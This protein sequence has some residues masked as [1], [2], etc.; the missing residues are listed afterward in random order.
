[1]QG[2]LPSQDS[3]DSHDAC[4]RSAWHPSRLLLVEE[5]VLC[6]AIAAVGFVYLFTWLP[7]PSVPVAVARSME[8]LRNPFKAVPPE[9]PVAVVP[10]S[11]MMVA[12]IKRAQKLEERGR[13]D[14][15]TRAAWK[16]AG[17]ELLR[18]GWLPIDCGQGRHVRL[19]LKEAEEGRTAEIAGLLEQLMP[20]Q[21]AALEAQRIV[22]VEADTLREAT[23]PQ[24]TWFTVAAN[25]PEDVREMATNLAAMHEEAAANAR[26]I[27]KYRDL[28]G[29]DYWKAVC[30]AG[31]SEPGLQARAALW[32]ADFVANQDQLEQAK[33]AYE[34]G[35]QAWQA[36]CGIV[37]AL[38]SNPHVA[39]DMSVHTGR[40]R[41]VLAALDAA[42]APQEP[43]PSTIDL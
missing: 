17:D 31:A 42:S 36:A 33:A 35:F 18:L 43:S 34:E 12:A 10:A 24:V 20:G 25:A 16:E 27:G 41:A 23:T 8:Q 6:G 39:E 22:A 15:A 38:G 28:V 40:Y 30:Q 32:L 37:P 7:K 29:Y 3:R 21:F 2:S 11:R 14:E 19:F 13:F 5:W 26:I 4:R 1:M 9:K